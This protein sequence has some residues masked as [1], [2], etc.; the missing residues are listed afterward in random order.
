MEFSKKDGLVWTGFIWHRTET[1]DGFGEYGKAASG[2]I[3]C[4]EFFEWPCYFS[5]L[6][7]IAVRRNSLVS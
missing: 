1:N 2:S 3:K 4:W 5:F 7:K 6:K